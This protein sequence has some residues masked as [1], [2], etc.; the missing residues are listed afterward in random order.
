MTNNHLN[1]VL[2]LIKIKVAI[3]AQ[4][5]SQIFELSNNNSIS[6]NEFLIKRDELLKMQ[7]ILTEKEKLQLEYAI[8][9][10]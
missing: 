3:N 4:I 9:M 10:M 6:N 5:D 7:I 2:E 1:K 8:C